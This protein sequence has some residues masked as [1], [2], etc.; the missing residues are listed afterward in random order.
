M[1]FGY[2][3]SHIDI[4]TEEVF[5]AP[6]KNTLKILIIK[7]KNRISIKFLNIS[8]NQYIYLGDTYEKKKVFR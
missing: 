2:S 1:F 7:F 3:K 6:I 5:C 4:V 8:L